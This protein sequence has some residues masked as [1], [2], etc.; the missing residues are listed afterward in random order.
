MV[1][2]IRSPKIRA[3]F[4]LW[5]LRRVPVL[6]FSNVYRPPLPYCRSPPLSSKP[7]IAK[8]FLKLPY[9][10]YFLLSPSSIFKNPSD[11]IRATQVIQE[12]LFYSKVKP[13][14]ALISS[15]NLNLCHVTNHI[16]R[17]PGLR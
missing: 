12:N 7:T 3:A 17:F 13:L 10:W 15:A 5:A 6:A 16:H 8:P 2:V 9:L 11:Y 4:L 1:L 14:A